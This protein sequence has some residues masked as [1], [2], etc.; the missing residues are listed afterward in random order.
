MFTLPEYQS[1]EAIAIAWIVVPVIAFL[2]VCVELL[3]NGD[4]EMV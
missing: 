4:G 3:I 1:G 2:S